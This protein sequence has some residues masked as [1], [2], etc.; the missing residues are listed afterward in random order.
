MACCKKYKI[1]SYS[2]LFKNYYLLDIQFRTYQDINNITSPD[3][4]A[5]REI[6]YH[7]QNIQDVHIANEKIIL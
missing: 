7:I 1:F 3:M 4:E 2:A 5:N 6:K